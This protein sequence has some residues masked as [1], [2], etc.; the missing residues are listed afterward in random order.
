MNDRRALAKMLDF[1]HDTRWEKM[2]NK[3]KGGDYK[4][5]VLK[6]A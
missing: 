1:I 3:K 4:G 2:D 5:Y 6:N